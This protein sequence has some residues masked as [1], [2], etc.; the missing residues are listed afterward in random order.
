MLNE[1]E[2]IET[3]YT[4]IIGDYK[5]EID[6]LRIFT[7]RVGSTRYYNEYYSLTVKK[8]TKRKYWFGHSVEKVFNVKWNTDN[9]KLSE[10]IKFSQ[11]KVDTFKTER[12]V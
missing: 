3:L 4:E 6:L 1:S 7:S 9:A 8:K 11:Q 2:T 12:V 10:M 5:V